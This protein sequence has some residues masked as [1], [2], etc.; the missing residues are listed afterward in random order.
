MVDLKSQNIQWNIPTFYQ[1]PGRI[2]DP[3]KSKIS[4]ENRGIK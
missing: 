3:N 1:T 2:F 4:G